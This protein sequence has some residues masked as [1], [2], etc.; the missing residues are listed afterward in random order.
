MHLHRRYSLWRSES[1]STIKPP[2]IQSYSFLI[3]ADTHSI[4]T[5][6]CMAYPGFPL[7]NISLTRLDSLGRLS[8]LHSFDFA[9]RPLSDGARTEGIRLPVVLRHW[10]RRAQACH[11]NSRQIQYP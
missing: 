9:G 10:L 11:E 5:V 6:G 4:V 1:R 7:P 2:R 8:L 3:G